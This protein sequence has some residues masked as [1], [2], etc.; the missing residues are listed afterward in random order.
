MTRNV[1]VVLVLG[2]LGV[3]AMASGCGMAT[4][5]MEGD[6]GNFGPPVPVA[7]RSEYRIQP[8]D[9]LDIRFY[10]HP[11][12]N[13]DAVLVQP[14]GKLD[15]PLVGEVVAAGLTPAQLSKDLVRRYSA[16]LRGPEVA[17]RVKTEAAQAQP[18]VYVGG[19][20]AKPGFLNFRPGMTAAQAII[21]AGG[22]KDTA[23][24]TDIVLLRKVAEPDE[25]RPAKIDLAR[26][27]EEGDTRANVVLGP[28]DI[29]VVP[30]T[31]IAKLNVFVEQF[32]I[33]LIPVR[34]SISPI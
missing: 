21:E 5:P 19:E 10:Y 18:R 33:K 8:G 12:H 25:Y 11:D 27:I 15:L 32:I 29:L 20:V 22:H 7:A 34:V 17:V 28:S 16:N 30:K 26:V 23:A 13:Q 3:L 4:K 31:A 2:L 24:I 9:I 14:D 6:V 1:K